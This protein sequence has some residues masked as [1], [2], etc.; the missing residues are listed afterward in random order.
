MT[1]LTAPCSRLAHQSGDRSS[2]LMSEH[3][4]TGAGRYCG[5]K[6]RRFGGI[7]HLIQFGL[8]DEPRCGCGM[9]C[10]IALVTVSLIGD[11]RGEPW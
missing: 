7:V 8:E 6:K 9:T 10:G 5:S 1:Q 11:L 4:G 3:C 2:V